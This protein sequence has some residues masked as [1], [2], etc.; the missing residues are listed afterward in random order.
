MENLSKSRIVWTGLI[1]GLIVGFLNGFFGGGGGMIVVPLLV[2]LLKMP[3]KKAHATAIFVI[4]PLCIV[5]SIVYII[6]GSIDW[7][8]LLYSSIGFVV[9]GVVGALLLKKLNNK[10]LRIIFSL[11]MIGAGIKLF[12]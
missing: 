5:S 3:E 11:I 7:L 6:K 4:L 2:F 8:Q 1:G 12:F 10:V 9:G